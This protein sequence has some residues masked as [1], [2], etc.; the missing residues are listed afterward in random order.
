MEV[1]DNLNSTP[2]MLHIGI[3]SPTLA[4]DIVGWTSAMVGRIMKHPPH[5]ITTHHHSTT[6]NPVTITGSHGHDPKG[7]AYI[8]VIQWLHTAASSTTSCTRNSLPLVSFP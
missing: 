4:P 7:P 3:D 1:A 6:F 5:V 2:L 8:K